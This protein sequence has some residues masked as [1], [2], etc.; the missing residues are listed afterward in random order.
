MLVLEEILNLTEQGL[1]EG[2]R[3]LEV[4][5][6]HLHELIVDDGIVAILLDHLDAGFRAVGLVPGR[7]I[8]PAA[9]RC[10]LA[11]QRRRADLASDPAHSGLG[12]D[13]DEGLLRG[14]LPFPRV[15]EQHECFVAPK[16]SLHLLYR[17]RLRSVERGV[18]GKLRPQPCRSWL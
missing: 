16:Q 7:I 12:H 9:Q 15:E 1:V 3:A 14:R 17:Q 11:R 10:H 6:Q 2:M 18:V 4:E 13:P 5:G 8:Q